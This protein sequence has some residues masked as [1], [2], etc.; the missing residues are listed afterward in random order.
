MRRRKSIVHISMRRL[1]EG[2]GK[3]GAADGAARG[4][5]RQRVDAR[6]VEGV[7]GYQVATVAPA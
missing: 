3:V 4:G 5:A 2:G 7:I 1:G 6:D